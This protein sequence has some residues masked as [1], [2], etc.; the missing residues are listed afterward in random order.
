MKLSEAA[1]ITVMYNGWLLEQNRLTKQIFTN[2]MDNYDR[3][4]AADADAREKLLAAARY[5]GCNAKTQALNL[6]TTAS[7]ALL[8]WLFR[9]G[10]YNGTHKN[11]SAERDLIVAF[12]TRGEVTTIDL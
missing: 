9:G 3:R 1:S 11:W 8:W 2:A 12:N 5:I 7:T 6:R 4:Y 10:G